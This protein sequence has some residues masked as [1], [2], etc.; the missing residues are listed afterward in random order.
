MSFF[1]QRAQF[2]IRRMETQHLALCA[3]LHGK[4]FAA[5]WSESDLERM[6][7]DRNFIADCAV[8]ENGAAS[9]FMITRVVSDECEVLTLVTDERFR[10]RGIGRALATSQLGFAAQLGARQAFLEVAEGN[11]AAIKLYRALGFE[12]VGRRES[13]YP[14][15]GGGR[16]AALTMRLA[17][18]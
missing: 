3:R 5:G 18:F 14:G 7:F 6:L 17:L 8:G 16:I 15:A 13:Y 11:E 1:H 2:A 10:R 12:P 9:G 4:A